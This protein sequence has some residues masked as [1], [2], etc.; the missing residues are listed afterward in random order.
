MCLSAKT[1]GTSAFRE[2]VRAYRPHDS[3][4]GVDPCVCPPKPQAHL[5]SERASTPTQATRFE[6]R[7]R[8]MCLPTASAITFEPFKP[9]S[10]LHPDDNPDYKSC[11][12]DIVL[13]RAGRRRSTT[14]IFITSDYTPAQV[15]SHKKARRGYLRA[16]SFHLLRR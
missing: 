2:G 5:H 4:V 3:N 14:L 12:H 9:P 8:P 7:G 15:I 10:S 6:C 1:S 13:K 11:I 16:F